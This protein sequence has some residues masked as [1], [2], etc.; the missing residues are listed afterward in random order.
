M[1]AMSLA[2]GMSAL[3]VGLEDDEETGGLRVYLGHRARGLYAIVEDENAKDEL[4]RAWAQ[5][6]H[7]TLSP[8]P[9]TAVIWTERERP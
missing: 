8:K 5:G 9:P 4:R 2:L 7:V 3:V 6:G 1:S